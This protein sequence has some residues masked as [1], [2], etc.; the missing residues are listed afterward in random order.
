MEIRDGTIESGR[1]RWQLS[2]FFQFFAALVALACLGSL[3]VVLAFPAPPPPETPAP[4]AAS[5]TDQNPPQPGGPVSERPGPESAHQAQGLSP[6][7]IPVLA[8]FWIPQGPAPIDIS[9]ILTRGSYSQADGAIKAVAAH[10]NNADIIYVGTVNGGIWKTTNGTSDSPT[11]TPQTDGQTSLSIGDLK[12]DPTDPTSNTLIAGI[13]RYSA[14]LRRGGPRTGLLLTTDGGSTWKPIDGGGK[15]AGINISGVAAR[16]STLL[17]A[18]DNADNLVCNNVGLLRSTD[19]GKS[20]SL[21]SGT[22]G[23][24]LPGG[25]IFDLTEDP[26]NTAVLY[27]PVLNGNPCTSGGASGV[28][29]SVDTG[30]TWRLVSDA[31]INARFTDKTVNSKIAVGADNTVYVGIEN[32]G[33]LAGLFHSTDG[34]ATWTSLDVPD[35]NPFGQGAIH[36]SIVAD[37]KSRLWCTSPVILT[38]FA[39]TQPSHWGVKPSPYGLR[40]PPTTPRL[41]LIHAGWCLTPTAICSKRTTAES[42]GALARRTAPAIGTP[43]SATSKSLSSLFWPTTVIRKSSSVARRITAR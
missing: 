18:A 15:L 3:C 8:G 4:V 6:S 33:Q 11:W 42:I 26:G 16:G 17:A 34:G 29:K 1:R 9:P 40:A 13:G 27:A 30:A 23:T 43:W 25:R 41:T 19:D 36:F 39:S 22:A 14:Y 20:F 5:A 31:T 38:C 2:S 35:I 28:Y 12:F 37:A 32:S 24:G 7:A 21:V 10:P